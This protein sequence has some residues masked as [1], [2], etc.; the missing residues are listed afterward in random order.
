[1]KFCRGGGRGGRGRIQR[2]RKQRRNRGNRKQICKR[3]QNR[4]GRGQKRG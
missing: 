4:R 3:G 1:M 2:T